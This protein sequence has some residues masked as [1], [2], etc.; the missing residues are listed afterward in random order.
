[1]P[2]CQ[3][4][5]EAEFPFDGRKRNGELSAREGGANGRNQEMG[6]GH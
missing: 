5:A 4:R 6:L 3:M 1:M 2:N